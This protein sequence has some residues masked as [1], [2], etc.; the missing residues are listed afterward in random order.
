LLRIYRSIREVDATAW[1]RLAGGNAFALHGWFLTTEITCRATV[2]P[3]YFALY[4]NEALVAGAVCYVVNAGGIIET[5]DDMIFGRCQRFAP[6]LLPAL[7][8]GPILGYGWHIGVAPGEDGLEAMPVVLDAMEAEARAR[9]LDLSFTLVLDEEGELQRLLG[10]RSYSRC[11]NVPIAMLDLPWN[12][13]EEYLAH[14]PGKTRGEFRR[15]I[16]RNRR[17]GSVTGLSEGNEGARLLEL[18]DGNSRRYSQLPFAFGSGFFDELRRSL[19]GQA[20]VFT[21]WKKGAIR[22][23]STL[24]VE[25]R[26][27]YAIAAGVDRVS[28]G[29]DFTYFQVGYYTPIAHAIASG[30]RRIYYGRGMYEVK[31]RRGCRLADSWVYMRASGFRRLIAAFWFPVASYWNRR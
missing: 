11:R 30:I 27:A 7:V 26:T 14:L 16:H 17:E 28:A 15:Q 19:N 1:N 9:R 2:E 22:G 31:I 18:V 8:C 4:R 10:A 23:T 29:D 5:L 13:F 20:R 3:L 25:N 24:L 12:S 21:A 6:S